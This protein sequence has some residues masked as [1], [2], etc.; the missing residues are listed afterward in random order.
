LAERSLIHTATRRLDGFVRLGLATGATPQATTQL[1]AGV[2]LEAPFGRTD[3]R[4]GLAVS[5]V[6]TSADFRREQAI[7]SETP[8]RGEVNYELTYQLRLAPWLTVQP[9]LQYVVHPA[10]TRDRGDAVVAGVRT[11]VSW[12]R[13]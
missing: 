3:D 12:S 1:N 7:L 9:N 5:A 10:A 6:R 8:A 2:V 13:D 4:L 11:V